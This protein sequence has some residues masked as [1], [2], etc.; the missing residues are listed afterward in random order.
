M[1][2]SHLFFADD[3]FLFGRATEA[4]ANV[5][6]DVLDEFCR[7][8]GAKVSFEKSQLFVEPNG[9]ARLGALMS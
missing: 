1:S 8:S 4:Q 9:N 6:K 7:S 2:V 5:M 3:L